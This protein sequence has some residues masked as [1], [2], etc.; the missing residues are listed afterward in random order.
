MSHTIMSEFCSISLCDTD[1]AVQGQCLMFL[2]SSDEVKPDKGNNLE[3]GQSGVE[4][5][6]KIG[7]AAVIIV[8]VVVVVVVAIII[9]VII[10]K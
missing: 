4:S 10:T 3:W 5:S 7:M 6:M 8:I 2:A 9:I 1:E